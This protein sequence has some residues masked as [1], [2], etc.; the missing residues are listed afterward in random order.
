MGGGVRLE[1][2]ELKDE[3]GELVYKIKERGGAEL[4]VNAATGNHFIKG[5]YERV[6][7][8]PG[9]EVMARSTDW[10]K[11]L[12]DL[13]TGEIGGEAGKAIMSLA[14]LLL[15]LLTFSGVYLWLKPMLMRR[16]NVKARAITAGTPLLP[17]AD[18]VTAQ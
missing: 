2:I 18:P 12:I 7:Q 17:G 8:K 16:Q 1:R 11:L 4:W 6:K 5:E 9:G 13:H 10:G 3:H 14:A 15:L